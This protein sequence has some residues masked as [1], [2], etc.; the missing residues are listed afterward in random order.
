RRAHRVWSA[1]PE[2]RRAQD[3]EAGI[4]GVELRRRGI[5]PLE[6][7]RTKVLDEDVAQANQRQEHLAAARGTHVDADA[8]LVAGGHPKGA[9]RGCPAR[10]W[11]RRRS[12]A[13]RP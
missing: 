6:G 3:D 13:A 11:T 4:H 9:P 2:A 10:R 1:L 7:A 5:P 12:E 8:A